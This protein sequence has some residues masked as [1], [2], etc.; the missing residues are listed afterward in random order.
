MI[1][2]SARRGKKLG[3][4]EPLSIPPPTSIPECSRTS[5]FRMAKIQGICPGQQIILDNK[6]GFGAKQFRIPGI[7]SRTTGDP[8]ERNPG[9]RGATVLG[10]S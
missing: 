10:D 8:V 5:L 9:Q 6:L 3:H 4:L 2:D 7:S 1:V